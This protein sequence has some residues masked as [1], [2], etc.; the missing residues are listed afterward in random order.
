[1]AISSTISYCEVLEC[2]QYI[3]S[4]IVVK[5]LET[6]CLE[7]ITIFPNWN[8]YIPEKGDIGY[9]KYREVEAGDEYVTPTGERK[10]FKYNMTFFDKFV[11]KTEDNEELTI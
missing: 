10:N 8:G 1:M 9:I 7:I 4:N 6:E 5:D 2:D 3:Y 11:L